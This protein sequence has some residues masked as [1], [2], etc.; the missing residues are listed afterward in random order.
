MKRSTLKRP[1][2]REWFVWL[3]HSSLWKG[4]KLMVSLNPCT[5]RE[6]EQKAQSVL[7]WHEGATHL[8]ITKTRNGRESKRHVLRNR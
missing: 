2:V 1:E 5:R 3:R 6:A 8:K 4:W 7:Q